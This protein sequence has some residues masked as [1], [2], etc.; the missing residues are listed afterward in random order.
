[1]A[2][3]P[4]AGFD[5][6]E[7]INMP[8]TNDSGGTET[9]FLAID[10]WAGSRDK[11]PQDANTDLEFRLVIFETG[12]NLDYEYAP[13]GSVM[14]GHTAGDGVVSVGAV[15][16]W[17][18][19]RFDPENQG[20]TPNI[21]PEPFTSRG[22]SIPKFFNADGTFDESTGFSPDLAAVDGNNTSF[23]GQPSGGLPPIDGEPDGFPNFFGTSAAAPNAAAVAALLLEENGNCSPSEIEGALEDSA[24]DVTG[25]RAGPGRDKT[26]G[27]GLVD[28]AAA[29]EAV[30]SLNCASDS[31]GGGGAVSPLT[32]GLLGLFVL[33]GAGLRGSGRTQA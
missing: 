17:E 9:I 21:D 31:G 10:H 6:V 14:Y 8:Y 3:D 11:I 7:F 25:E 33:V 20:P 1:M 32:G 23:F 29:L 4:A 5:P 30:K 19:P 27:E 16:W 12:G 26:T 2:A 22:G 28:A 15:P 24:I 18:A 13:G